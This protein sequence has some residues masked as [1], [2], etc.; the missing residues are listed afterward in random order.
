[1][2]LANFQDNHDAG[3]I[4]E[5]AAREVRAKEKLK[6]FEEAYNDYCYVEGLVDNPA[7]KVG[8]YAW[9]HRHVL[10]GPLRY[11]NCRVE[12]LSMLT[13]LQDTLRD[14]MHTAAETALELVEKEKKD[15]LAKME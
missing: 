3:I 2:S 14:E 1:M 11:I 7:V 10:E 8:F 13:E 9:C 5:L 4:D 6:I 15:K 12:L